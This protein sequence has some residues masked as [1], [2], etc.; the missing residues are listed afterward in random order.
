MQLPGFLANIPLPV[1]GAVVLVGRHHKIIYRKAFGQAQLTPEP[2]P[3][4]VNRIFDLASVTKPV[5]TATS[6]MILIERGLLRLTDPVSAYIPEFRNYTGPDGQPGEPIRIYHLLTHTSGLPAYTN[7]KALREQYG[8]P[9]PEA[10]IQKIATLD[11]LNPPGEVFRYSCL[12]F[13]TLAEI[14]RRIS[15]QTIDRFAYE[16]IF[17]PLNLRAT[18]YC[19]PAAWRPWIAPTEVIEGQPLRDL[20]HD[21]LA[22]LMDGKSG[23]AGL[24]SSANDLAVFCQMMINGGVYGKTRILSPLTVQAM[25]TI[26]PKT[27]SAGR[28]L[29][30]DVYSDY[31][32]NMGD[33]LPVNA[34]GHTGFTGTSLVVDPET[35]TFIIFLSNRVHLPQG[36]VMAL[37]SQ[38]ANVVAASI[39]RR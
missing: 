15:G 35:R 9:C 39:T 34:Y 18:T 4:T 7:A 23:N 12:G 5:G 31:S 30:W 20:V 3:M 29:G 2:E 19:P 25:T 21:P 6:V 11:R 10:V 1:L 24:F 32:S 37:R 38:I 14:V 16:N 36:D 28:G 8:A 26:F 13:I 22:Q 17:K 33:L 27:A